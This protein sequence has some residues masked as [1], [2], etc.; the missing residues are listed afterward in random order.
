MDGDAAGAAAMADWNLQDSNGQHHAS[1]TSQR[2]LLSN[3]SRIAAMSGESASATG[4][5]IGAKAK[6]KASKG[7]AA[8]EWHKVPIPG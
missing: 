6:F 4:T 8:S 1:H 2:S 7:E 3:P 5:Q